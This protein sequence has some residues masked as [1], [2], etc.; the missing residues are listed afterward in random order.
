MFLSI[1]LFTFTVAAFEPGN[2][3]VEQ[4]QA[5]AKKKNRTEACA[6]LQKSLAEMTPASK[7]R[8]KVL[9]ALN[10]ISRLFF[11]DKGQKEFEAGQATMWDSP[12]M[13]LS[14][15]K[16]ALAVENDNLLILDNIVR[17]Q[18]MKQECDAAAGTIASARKINPYSSEAAILELRTLVCQR[19]FT[20]FKDKAKSI[21]TADKWEEAY[22]QYLIA[23]ELMQNQNWK[24]AFDTLSKVTEEQPQFPEAYFWMAKAG[25]ELEKDT[26]AQYQKYVSLCKALTTRDKRRFSLEPKLCVNQKDAEDE[27]VQKSKSN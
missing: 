27:L 1:L 2:S 23:Q 6:V 13:A 7:S 15:L 5:L 9:E 26:E 12:D 3:A 17:I 10:Q 11:T 22:I 20:G 21:V 25:I 19:D 14:H 8:P 16:T 18:L 24:K 4:A